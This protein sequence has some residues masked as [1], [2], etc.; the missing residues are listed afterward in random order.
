VA[1]HLAR[2]AEALLGVNPN[3]RRNMSHPGAM[4]GY[5]CGLGLLRPAKSD[6]EY[7]NELV[8]LL[9]GIERFH[10]EDGSAVVAA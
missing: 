4:T 1:L 9:H 6:F 5:P 8:F 10:L 3:F 2:L 7:R